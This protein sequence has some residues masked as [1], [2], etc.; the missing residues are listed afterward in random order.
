MASDPS[1]R[2]R[3]AVDRGIHGKSKM[4]VFCAR[5]S[6]RAIHLDEGDREAESGG[7]LFAEGFDAKG[8]RGIVA[9]EV[10]VEPVFLGKIEM[11]LTQFPGDEGIGL[12]RGQLGEGAAAGSREDGDPLWAGGPEFKGDEARAKA[13]QEGV[14]EELPSLR[15]AGDSRDGSPFVGEK[16]F[17]DGQ[18]EGIGEE[19]VVAYFRVRVER[20]VRAVDGEVVIQGLFQLIV[21]R[22]GVGGGS[23]PEEP[24][25]DNKE[26]GAGF[27]GEPKRFGSRVNGG[28]DLRN[29][30]VILELQA[31]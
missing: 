17:L 29:G 18:A 23:V 3:S 4:R 10:K 12:V 27:D 9:T 25:V 7:D 30:A 15:S 11:F 14:F 2:R 22:T 13:P 5:T 21:E 6:E 1:T 28:G 19:A 16:P 20:E 26:V 24:V 8:F 31:V